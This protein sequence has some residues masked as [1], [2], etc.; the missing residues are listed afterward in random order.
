MII[1]VTSC[2]VRRRRGRGDRPH[3]PRAGHG[4]VSVRTSAARA[5]MRRQV[6]RK[7]AAARAAVAAWVVVGAAAALA[8]RHPPADR[9]I[10]AALND[11]ERA[12]D[13]C[14]R[15]NS[16]VHRGCCPAPAAMRSAA[17]AVLLSRPL[18]L[19]RWRKGPRSASRRF[20]QLRARSTWNPPPSGP[21]RRR[22][23]R[24][25]PRPTRVSQSL[26]SPRRPWTHEARRRACSPATHVAAGRWRG[27][28]WNPPR[29]TR[30]AS[31]AG[32]GTRS[33]RW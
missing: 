2:S 21:R 18:W 3:P 13:F 6:R 30:S 7:P 16:S 27:P 20:V 31:S 9:R 29:G 25:L 14:A 22:R 19:F 4:V 8:D 17:G 24:P 26:P 5:I 12:P 11:H 33:R 23:R 1:K 10:F 28:P 32:S 15:S